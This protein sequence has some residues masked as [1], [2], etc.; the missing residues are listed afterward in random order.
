MLS[1][2][3]HLLICE[4][5]LLLDHAAGNVAVIRQDAIGWET[6]LKQ[7]RLA[8]GA[9][10]KRSPIHIVGRRQPDAVCRYRGASLDTMRNTGLAARHHAGYRRETCSSP[11][12]PSLVCA[13]THSTV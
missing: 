7:R 12:H 2:L 9:G 11:T 4:P 6:R 10:G 1:P 3:I 8:L 5:G 13:C